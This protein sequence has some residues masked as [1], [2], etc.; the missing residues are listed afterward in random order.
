MVP[1]PAHARRQ[2]R[3][4]LPGHDLRSR[5]RS[6]SRRSGATLQEI[7][8]RHE[9]LR[10]SFPAVDGLPVQVIHEP[11]LVELPVADLAG[12]P[13]GTAV[14]GVGAPRRRVDASAVRRG[15][16]AARALA[17]APPGADD[18]WELIQVEQHFVHDG[19]SFGVMLREIKAIYSAFLRG[20]PSPLPELPVQYA[21]FAAW[22]RELMEG[23]GMERLLGYW[24]RK[25]AGSSTFLELPTDRPRPARP[26]VRGGHCALSAAGRALRVA[27]GLRPARG[28]H[29][30]HDD[31]RRFL[32]A[33]EPLHG[34]GGHP[35][36]GPTTR[37]GGRARSK[38]CSA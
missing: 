34:P 36:S 20:E 3:L 23:G 16:P 31:A 11:W 25:L 6:T 28:V 27:P 9:V 19:W 30:V 37:T 18:Q 14:R 4:Q 2:H 22:Q 32:C 5:G 7:V 29:P 13:R 33:L 17:D 38:G 26:L 10:T 1:G 24:Q 35:A 21:D 15:P 12:P 8:R